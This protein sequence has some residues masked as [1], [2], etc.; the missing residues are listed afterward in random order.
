MTIRTSLM[1]ATVIAIMFA[2][3]TQPSFQPPVK[4]GAARQ[5]QGLGVTAAASTPQDVDKGPLD[6]LVA[7]STGGTAKKCPK[8]QVKCGT[9]GCY[10]PKVSCCCNTR[11]HT[12]QI[13]GK[14][15][16]SNCNEV[17]KAAIAP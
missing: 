15:N 9:A 3:V 14:R 13:F 17:C 12:L 10:D 1:I 5:F 7:C 6:H 2:G 8:G 16:Y 11:R 4:A